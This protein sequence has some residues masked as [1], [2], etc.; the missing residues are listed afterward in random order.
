MIKKM[1][2]G[3]KSKLIYSIIFFLVFCLSVIQI[4]II[5]SSQA[6]ITQ[7]HYTLEG[8]ATAFMGPG[9]HR[10]ITALDSYT[11]EY[12]FN[13]SFSSTTSKITV[14]A[15]REDDYSFWLIDAAHEKFKLSGGKLEDSDVWRFDRQEYWLIV[16]ENTG[17]QLTQINYYSNVVYIG[18]PPLLSFDGFLVY[19]IIFVPIALVL[20][21]GL[22]IF[23]VVRSRREPTEPSLRVERQPRLRRTQDQSIIR[24]ADLPRSKRPLTRIEQ[25]G[26]LA[27]EEMSR[28]N[29]NGAID[30]WKEIL[31]IDIENYLATAGL[32]LAYYT[33]KDFEKAV[34][35]LERAFILKP[36]ATNVA[37]LLSQA[38]SMKEELS[39]TEEKIEEIPEEPVI[40]DEKKP[41]IKEEK[42]E[43]K[44]KA[45]RKKKRK[46]CK[47]CSTMNELKA[48]FCLDC[49][50]KFEDETKKQN[51]NP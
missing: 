31:T 34:V 33:T 40:E 39:P 14:Y 37:G 45:K 49:G 47:E 11:N 2:K 18:E 19:I 17:S 27:L 15:M 46:K 9:E 6:K 51:N 36:S 32:G 43:E 38:K 48:K 29:P 7:S 5:S 4:S 23:F 25:K 21:V 44:K 41:E 50:T 24:D 16:F 8:C 35:M 12:G 3:N 20:I 10:Q 26:N 13:W 42:P 28:G 1:K 22:V 30:I